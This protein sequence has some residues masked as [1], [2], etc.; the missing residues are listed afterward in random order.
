M[1]RITAALALTGL[2][3][4]AGD[5]AF[6]ETRIRP[7]L[8][9]QCYSCHAQTAMAGLRL[10]SRE[11]LL[12]G[13]KS[14][15]AVEPGKADASLLIQAVTHSHGKLKMPPGRKLAEREIADLRAWVE[16]G[17][18]WPAEASGDGKALWSLRPV[19]EAGGGV[20]RWP[21]RGA[22]GG[23]GAAAGA[24]GGQADAAAPGDL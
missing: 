4:A 12:R 22:V 15:A 20:N 24:G 11:G 14:G 2:A 8:A 19:A 7:L 10:D 3:A 5:A 17:A 1:I 9:R 13:G 23:R 6:F 16:D 21:D 18:S